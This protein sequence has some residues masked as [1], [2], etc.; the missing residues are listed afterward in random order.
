MRNIQLPSKE[1]SMTNCNEKTCGSC[2]HLDCFEY[3]WIVKVHGQDPQIFMILFCKHFSRWAQTTETKIL[4][5]EP[6]EI[7]ENK[8]CLRHERCLRSEIVPPI[9]REEDD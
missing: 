6:L 2:K 8:A 1:I 5:P 9:E 3:P 7:D 4:L